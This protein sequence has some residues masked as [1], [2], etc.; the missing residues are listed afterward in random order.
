M[1]WM[2][3]IL[4]KSNFDG[5]FKANK[6]PLHFLRNLGLKCS[7]Y[8]NI[9][10]P[11]LLFFYL[12]TY[13]VGW[14]IFYC[15]IGVCDDDFFCCLCFILSCFRTSSFFS[16]KERTGLRETVIKVIQK[17]FTPQWNL[18]T[19]GNYSLLIAFVPRQYYISGILM[20]SHSFDWKVWFRFIKAN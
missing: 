9:N 17:Y 8:W 14:F 7:G 2:P 15:C 6:A 11:F 10:T 12:I 19:E 4:G 16:D 13:H 20:Q 18:G 5:L 1:A 3:P